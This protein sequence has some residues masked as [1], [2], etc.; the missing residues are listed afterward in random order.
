MLGRQ[1]SQ[2]PVLT[3]Q[4]VSL[5][6]LKHQIH[7]RVTRAPASKE[8]GSTPEDDPKS[9]NCPLVSAFTVTCTHQHFK[10]S[11]SF[12]V[13]YV[14]ELCVQMWVYAQEYS[15]HRGRKVPCN[16]SF[17]QFVTCLTWVVE[18]ELRSSGRVASPRSSSHTH[19]FKERVEEEEKHPSLA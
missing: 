19:E 6:S 13:N 8:V 1:T 2:F 5:A 11:L 10:V 12:I 17:R 7:S 9:Q 16:Q 4:P 14:Y 18:T 3:S 15:A